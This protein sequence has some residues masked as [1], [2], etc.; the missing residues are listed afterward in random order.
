MRV[1]FFDTKIDVFT[2]KETLQIIIDSIEAKIQLRHTL[3]NTATLFEM[4]KD[5][6]LKNV[7]E[8]SDLIS[9]DGMGLIFAY[10]I[11]NNVKLEKIAGPNIMQDLIDYCHKNSKSIFLL[12]A[13]QEVVQNLASRL[14]NNYSKSLIAGY[15]NGFFSE[16][17]L[18]TLLKT[19]QNSSPD[20]LFVGMPTPRKEFFLY[21]NQKYLNGISLLLGV[22]G[23]FD[24][25]AG[26]TKRAPLWMQNNGLEWLFRLLQEP[27]RLFMR[28]L[29][30]NFFLIKKIFLN[31]VQK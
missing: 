15:H 16:S 13:Q 14:S 17:D 18:P 29:S 23:C 9:V 24:L 11:L 27:K 30:S 25:L 12:G 22:G 8:S 6:N 7:I 5:Q 28:Y 26:K 10:E 1:N 19:I 31:K 4:E 21:E 2:Y 20:I 3:I